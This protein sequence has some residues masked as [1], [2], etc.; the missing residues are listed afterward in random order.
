MATIYPVKP[1]RKLVH[2]VA[3]LREPWCAFVE[4]N[5]FLTAVP[6]AALFPAMWLAR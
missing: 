1:V 6:L 3:F 2:P 5:I 4:K